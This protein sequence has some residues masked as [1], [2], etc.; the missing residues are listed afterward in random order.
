MLP[1]VENIGR[2][3]FVKLLKIRNHVPH[4]YLQYIHSFLQLLFK[5]A[6]RT[7]GALDAL[8]LVQSFKPTTQVIVG[9]NTLRE[10]RFH[11]LLGVRLDGP[12]VLFL[13][14]SVFEIILLDLT[15]GDF[16][17][18]QMLCGYYQKQE[19]NTTN[20]F[21]NFKCFLYNISC[22]CFSLS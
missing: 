4:C 18:E 7:R 11:I 12:R 20:Y 22:L 19:K 1:T 10:Q 2:M 5:G 13:W 17:P 8:Y 3:T 15:K 6:N 16:I 9:I 21:F 14:R